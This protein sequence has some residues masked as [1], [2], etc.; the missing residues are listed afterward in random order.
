M[1]LIT[2]RE[3]MAAFKLMLYCGYG[4]DG[5]SGVWISVARVLILSIGMRKFRVD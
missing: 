3:V 1:N 4:G 2:I 5:V